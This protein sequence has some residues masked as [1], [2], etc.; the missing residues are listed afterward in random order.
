I[1]TYNFRECIPQRKVENWQYL[2]E[3]KKDAHQDEVWL[4]KLSFRSGHIKTFKHTINCHVFL[5]F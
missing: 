3:T 1:Q 2:I 4:R 5:A